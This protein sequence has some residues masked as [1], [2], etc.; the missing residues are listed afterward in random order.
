MS[1]ENVVRLRPTQLADLDY[2]L[3]A[4]NAPENAI[5][6]RQWSRDRHTAVIAAADEAHFTLEVNGQPVGYAIL[7]DLA[8]P[9]Q[10]VLLR[11]LVVTEKGKGYGRQALRLIAQAA[12][13]TYNAHR[14]WLDVKPTNDRAKA[15]YVKTGFVYEGCLRESLKTPNGFESMEIMSMLQSEYRQNQPQ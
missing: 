5:Y 7:E 13:E 15:L 12:F 14:L 8:N 9:D 10:S 4:E 1:R 6:I 2:V 3:T 11:R